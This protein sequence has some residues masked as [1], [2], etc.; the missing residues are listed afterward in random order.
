[1]TILKNSSN[2]S[3]EF[4]GIPSYYTYNDFL[5]IFAPKKRTHQIATGISPKLD[6]VLGFVPSKLLDNNASLFTYLIQSKQTEK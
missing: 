5:K 1:M 4:G 2:C 6:F 3:S